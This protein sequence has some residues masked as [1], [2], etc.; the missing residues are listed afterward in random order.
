MEEANLHRVID[1]A[2][3][4]WYIE[5]LTDQLSE[6]AWEKFQEIES[7]GGIVDELKAGNLQDDVL[8]TKLEIQKRIAD[9]NQIVGGVNQFMFDDGNGLSRETHPKLPSRSVFEEEV[10]SL[11]P[12]RQDEGFEK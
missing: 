3:G 4:S 11:Q 12:Y 9:G 7:N 2:G 6:L 1:P 5:S 8:E 10:K